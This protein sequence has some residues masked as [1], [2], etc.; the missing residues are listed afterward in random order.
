MRRKKR[1]EE[2]KTEFRFKRM[3]KVILIF[4][5]L[6]LVLCVA[7]RNVTY[8]KQERILSLLE[9]AEFTAPLGEQ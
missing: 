2:Q 5:A 9:E 8:T 1:Q 4:L 6:A 3:Q 7:Q